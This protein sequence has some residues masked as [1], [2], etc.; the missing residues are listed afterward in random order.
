LKVIEHV[1]KPGLTRE[2][3]TET[4][5]PTISIKGS[6]ANPDLVIQMGEVIVGKPDHASGD[7]ILQSQGNSPKE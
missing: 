4:I 7:D 2:C 3:V 6:G 1:P 5:K